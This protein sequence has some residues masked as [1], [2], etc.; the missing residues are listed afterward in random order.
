MSAIQSEQLSAN[1]VT[2]RAESMSS[3]VVSQPIWIAKVIFPQNLTKQG[4]SKPSY[5]NKEHFAIL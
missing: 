1:A 2:R 4:L 5:N 3:D